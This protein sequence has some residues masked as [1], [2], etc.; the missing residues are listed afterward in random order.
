MDTRRATSADLARIGELL[1]AESL[2]RVPRNLPLSNL[3]VGIQEGEL[4]GEVALE[5]SARRGLLRAVV[6]APE[7]RR[8]GFGASLVTSAVA[9]AHELGLLDLHCATEKGQSFLEAQGFEPVERD[10]VPREIRASLA[11][12]PDSA[13]VLRMPLATQL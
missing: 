8:R 2:P 6:V 7:R 3:L 13:A 9:R 10:G 1:E 5:V 11:D 12:F 4:V